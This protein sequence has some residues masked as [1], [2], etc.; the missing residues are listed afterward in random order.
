MSLVRAVWRTLHRNRMVSSLL[1]VQEGPEASIEAG[2]Q[3]KDE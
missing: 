2:F 1:E 3:L